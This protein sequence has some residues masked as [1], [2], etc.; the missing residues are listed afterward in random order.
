MA[1]ADGGDTE[2]LAAGWSGEMA[3][4]EMNEG[5]PR[6]SVWPAAAEAAIFQPCLV[7]GGLGW[8]EHRRGRRD[9]MR[10]EIT[11]GALRSACT[12]GPPAKCMRSR[13]C[14]VGRPGLAQESV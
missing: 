4:G 11:I 6:I 13:R 2:A 7:S 10:P 14:A 8:A 5:A 1:G 3:N 9:E 12:R